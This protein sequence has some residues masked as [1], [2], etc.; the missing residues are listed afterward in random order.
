MEPARLGRHPENTQRAVL[1]RVFGVRAL[2]FLRFELR[3]LFLE[4]VRNVFQK[5]QPEDNMLVF[6]SIHA[7]A[8]RICHLP[9]LLLVPDVGTIG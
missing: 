5:D 4:R 1:V 2:G 8:Q 3:V 7:A 9:E 6:G